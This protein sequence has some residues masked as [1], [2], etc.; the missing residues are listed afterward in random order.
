MDE[1]DPPKSSAD[2]QELS[3][4][5]ESTPL[6]LT[7]KIFLG[8]SALSDQTRKKKLCTSSCI[9][10][11]AFYLKRKAFFTEINGVLPIIV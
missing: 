6:T 2:F 7:L 1:V 9:I 8:I 10:H 5:V 11:L 4:S 3:L